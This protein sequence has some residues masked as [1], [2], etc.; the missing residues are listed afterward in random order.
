MQIFR[1]K[2]ISEG[3][4]VLPI[5]LI[6]LMMSCGI[7][8]DLKDTRALGKPYFEKVEE[9]Y[10]KHAD[11]QGFLVDRESYGV[12]TST[13][14]LMAHTIPITRSLFEKDVADGALIGYAYLMGTG[15]GFSD[16]SDGLYTL[17][18]NDISDMLAVN[19]ASM[20]PSYGGAAK[21]L[22]ITVTQLEDYDELNPGNVCSNILG[23]RCGAFYIDFYWYCICA[24]PQLIE[25]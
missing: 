25:E 3:K 12:T 11:R 5:L 24:Y 2:L 15:E 20:T 23:G 17:K 13:D 22:A 9:T 8:K 4:K 14:M 1:R 7:A 19:S 18:I 6:A 16:E 10:F 21:N